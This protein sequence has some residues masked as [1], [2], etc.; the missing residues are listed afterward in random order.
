MERVCE[1]FEIIH[2]KR[3]IIFF[4]SNCR[5]D[6]YSSNR[7]QIFVKSC[8]DFPLPNSRICY[9]HNDYV[10]DVAAVACRTFVFLRQLFVYSVIIKLQH[11]MLRGG[12]SLL[13]NRANERRVH[14]Q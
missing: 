13:H 12:L 10:G 7:E 8:M 5:T 3:T 4:H 14:Y 1:Q 6:I 2:T 9:K 11:S